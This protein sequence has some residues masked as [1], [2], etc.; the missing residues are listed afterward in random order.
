MLPLLLEVPVFEG[1]RIH[2][3]N[4]DPIRKDVFY[5][6]KQD[7]LTLWAAVGLHLRLCLIKAAIQKEK[8]FIT[9]K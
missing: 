2:P 6:E 5:R 4:T 9:V 8:V 3:D 7:L 1:I